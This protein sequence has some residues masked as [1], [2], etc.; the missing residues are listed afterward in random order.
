MEF[1]ELINTRRSIRSYDTGKKVTE[2]QVK[3]IIEA[4]I[5]T[6]SWKN[7]QTARYYC[8][9]SDEMIQKVSSECLP[10]FNQKSSGGASLIVTTFVKQVSGHTNGE[11]D[12]ELGDGWGCYDLG[13][14]NENFILKAKEM[15]LGTLIMGI[16]NAEKIREILQIPEEE[17]I[18]AVIALG[19]PLADTPKRP[20]K[21]AEEIAKFY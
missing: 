6:P 10:P 11:P 18:V 13:L 16:R 4:A 5:Q 19:Y 8:I 2:A 15:G 9:L 21:T 7:S 14:H 17:I 12:N 3:E 20:R 1:Q